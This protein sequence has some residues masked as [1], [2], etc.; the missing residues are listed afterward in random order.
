MARQPSKQKST[1]GRRKATLHEREVLKAAKARGLTNIDLR[2]PLS[3]HARALVKKFEPVYDQTAS[4]VKV[5]A[6]DRKKI[7]G[8]TYA[9]GHAIIPKRTVSEVA[10]YDKK[11]GRIKVFDSKHGTV[12]QVGRR[13]SFKTRK[14]IIFQAGT[15]KQRKRTYS[16][17]AGGGAQNA[18]AMYL[19]SYDDDVLAGA[20][21]YDEYYDPYEG[22]WQRY[23]GAEIEW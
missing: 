3:R 18:A 19:A 5:P 2:K 4:V 23:G 8:V 6:K 16:G 11:T 1:S 7:L 21:I 9:K 14:V 12:R 20:E 15:S 22:E 10:R 17:G 13:I